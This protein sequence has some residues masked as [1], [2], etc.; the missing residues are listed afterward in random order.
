M[1]EQAGQT[2]YGLPYDAATNVTGVQVQHTGRRFDHICTG[3]AYVL[4][5]LPANPLRIQISD[6]SIPKIQSAINLEASHF[7]G[8][9]NPAISPIY[10]YPT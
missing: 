3:T 9:E 6:V 5:R 7:L 1:F 4:S 2:A 8:L 10:L